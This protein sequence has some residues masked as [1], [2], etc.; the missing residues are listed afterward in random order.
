MAGAMEA[1]RDKRHNSSSRILLGHRT[2]IQKVPGC[3][4]QTKKT[5]R[6]KKAGHAGKG[7][8]AREGHAGMV[9][10]G[11]GGKGRRLGKGEANPKS[12]GKKA[13]NP[14]K[15]LSQSLVC[16]ISELQPERVKVKSPKQKSPL[17]LTLD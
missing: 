17:Y 16:R 13:P 12:S 14:S 15:K 5:R 10:E 7:R 2:H 4:T 6:E 11:T 8:P 3:I 9:G 1:Q